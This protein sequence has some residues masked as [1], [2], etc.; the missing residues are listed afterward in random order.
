LA[1]NRRYDY[2]LAWVGSDDAICHI[3]TGLH[4]VPL[5][6]MQ[7]VFWSCLGKNRIEILEVIR[8]LGPFPNVRNTL[9]GTTQL[10]KTT[11][12]SAIANENAVSTLNIVMDSM[13]DGTGKQI[14]AGTAD[15]IRRVEL[16]LY[17]ADER[18]MVAVVPG[19]DGKVRSDP[20]ENNGSNVLVFL[21]EEA[22]D[23]KLDALRVS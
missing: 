12:A 18:V 10:G 19:T 1:G 22:L 23:D 2:R 5:A 8:I 20:L 15:N 9:Q 4:K 16:H 11:T 6:R 3:G 7:E 14:L 21:R 13:I 17:Y